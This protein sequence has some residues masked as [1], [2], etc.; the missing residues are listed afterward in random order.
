MRREARARMRGIDEENGRGRGRVRA[1][2]LM[3]RREGSDDEIVSA[4]GSA[5]GI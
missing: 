5:V 3:P 1:T 4:R 2:L